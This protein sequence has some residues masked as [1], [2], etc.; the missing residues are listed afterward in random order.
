MAALTDRSAG[1]KSSTFEPLGFRRFPLTRAVLHSRTM[2]P[3][4][5]VVLAPRRQP[6]PFNPEP[7]ITALDLNRSAGQTMTS[8]EIADLTGKEHKNVLANI[9]HMFFDLGTSSG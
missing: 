4:G 6:A 9:R 3:Q 5:F 7:P 2:E 1:E 8:R